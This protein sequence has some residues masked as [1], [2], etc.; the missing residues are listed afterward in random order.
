MSAAVA[1]R[2]IELIC[3]DINPAAAGELEPDTD[4]LLTGL[5]DS[6]GVVRIVNWIEDELEVEVDP[7]DVTL[8]N[9]QTVSAMAAYIDSR[10][11]D[12]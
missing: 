9:F 1:D 10:R 5:V 6:L 7:I 4:L 3:G 12:D 2:L 8:E 11:A